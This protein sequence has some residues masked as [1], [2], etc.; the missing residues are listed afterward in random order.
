MWMD[1]ALSVQDPSKPRLGAPEATEAAPPRGALRILVVEDHDD[2]RAATIATLCGFGHDARGAAHAGELAQQ[3]AQFAPHIVVLDLGLPGEDGLSLARRLRADDAALGIVIVTARHRSDDRVA[4][5]DAGADIYLTKP[6]SPEE[7]RAAIAAI[8]R[9]VAPA[10]EAAT[11]LW[12]DSVILQLAGPGGEVDV[13]SQ[14]ATLLTALA[15][16]PGRRLT[17]AELATLTGRSTDTFGKAALE[18][19]IV[20]LRKKLQQAGA[21]TPT[22][23]AIRGS[24][25]Q[26]CIPLTIGQRPA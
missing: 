21:T 13:S 9:R 20:R 26:L 15:Q 6:A 25:Y 7:L 1:S 12:L 18:V 22:I 10:D 14:E 11:G 16:A 4:G 8:G 19:Q 2:L 5:F 23:K 3:R 17:N 24:G